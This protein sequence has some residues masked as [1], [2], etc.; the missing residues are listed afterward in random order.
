MMEAA[1]SLGGYRAMSI[2][3]SGCS[4]LIVEDEPLITMEIAHALQSA[5]ASVRT[6]TTVQHAL[7]LAEEPAISVAIIDLALGGE[8]ALALCSRLAQRGVPFVIYTGYTNIPADCRPTAVLQK[9]A[10]PTA[11][12]HVVA[13]LVPK[14]L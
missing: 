8:M 4:I 9:P 13:A 5:R 14:I 7:Q 11:I 10:H 2:D 12:L 3:L 1:S 6:A